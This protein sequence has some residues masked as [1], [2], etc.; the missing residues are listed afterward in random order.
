MSLPS[1]K[2]TCSV[3][4]YHDG[5]SYSTNYVY[6]GLK[7]QEPILQAAWCSYCNKVVDAISSFTTEE[8]EKEISEL[9]V[10]INRNRLGFFAKYSK[11]KKESIK[12]LKEEIDKIRERI[13]YFSK[14]DYSCK[15]IECGSSKVY[16]LD[17]PYYTPTIQ[18]LNVKH[19]CG[20]ELLVSE[21]VRI[22]Y[23]PHTEVRSE[24][25]FNEHGKISTHSLR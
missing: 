8:A 12:E 1:Y 4:D 24:V 21:P 25:R 5:Y 23:H 6:Q 14:Q 3:C 7:S 16:P 19:S 9:N 18:S 17:I 2:I 22:F 10:F 11:S 15:C 13:L 20:G